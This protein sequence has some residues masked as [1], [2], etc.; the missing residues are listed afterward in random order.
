MPLSYLIFSIMLQIALFNHPNKNHGRR[1]MVK[2]EW[3]IN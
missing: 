1:R 3:F 2:I